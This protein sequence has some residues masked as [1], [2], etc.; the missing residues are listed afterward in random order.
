MMPEPAAQ[1]RISPEEKEKASAVAAMAANTFEEAKLLSPPQKSPLMSPGGVVQPLEL[2][3]NG[4]EGPGQEDSSLD[5]VTIP[6]LAEELNNIEREKEPAVPMSNSRLIL[7]LADGGGKTTS[8]GPAKMTGR[9]VLVQTSEGKLIAIPAS[10]LVAGDPPPPRASSAPPTPAERQTD[11]LPTR[12]ASVETQLRAG[13]E[14][15]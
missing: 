10:S 11:I 12:P 6:E 13:E 15:T 1:C 8:A 2:P 4:S 5:N 9:F 3:E 14:K 7:K